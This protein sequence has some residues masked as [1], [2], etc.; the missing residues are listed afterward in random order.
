[1]IV[2]K[3]LGPAPEDT[4][5]DRATPFYT[6]V[7][8]EFCLL[9]TYV[10]GVDHGRLFKPRNYN[11][12]EFCVNFLSLYESDRLLT[13]CQFTEVKERDKAARN[14]ERRCLTEKLKLGLKHRVIF[15]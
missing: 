5:Q 6:D 4:S 7:L 1:M 9:S 8:R 12:E 14:E 15:N 10:V 3:Q 13:K 11:M 2:R